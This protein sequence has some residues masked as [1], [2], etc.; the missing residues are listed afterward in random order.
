[1]PDRVILSP[2]LPALSK[3][4]YAILTCHCAEGEDR[5]RTTQRNLR[6]AAGACAVTVRRHLAVLVE[7]GLRLGRA[8][9]KGEAIMRE[10][11]SL[12]VNRD[13]YE[14]NARPGFLVN[15]LT[16]EKMEYDRFYPPSVALE[17]NGPQHSGPTER[18]PDNELARL[19]LARDLMKEGIS[20]HRGVTLI[21]VDAKDLSL[22]GMIRRVA[23]HLPV[24]RVSAASDMA[25]Y[26]ETESRRY[27]RS[28][29]LG[30]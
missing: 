7:C 11:L 28:P 23:A 22:E 2:E 8:A 12:I 24:R 5:C 15:P 3:V 4:L 1:L 13:D 29:Y 26:L 19:Q 6:A 16:N 21:T 18:F 30:A 25:A 14:D 27:R 10:W 20:R 17:F 9:F